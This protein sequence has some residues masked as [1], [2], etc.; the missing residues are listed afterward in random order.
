M[1]TKWIWVAL[2]CLL[3]SLAW[4]DIR[5][6]G[7]RGS[8]PFVGEASFWEDEHRSLTLAQLRAGADVH[9]QPLRDPSP[10]FSFS[11]SRYG[12]HFPLHNV[13]GE[14]QALVLDMAQ[15]LQDYLT[16]TLVDARGEVVAEWQTGDRLPA[17]SRALA[18]RGFAFPLPLAPNQRYDLYVQLD[19][20]DGLYDA[21]PLRLM[22]EEAFYNYRQR[23]NFGFGFYYGAIVILLLYNLVV[24]VSLKS[25]SFLL[26]SLYLTCF[27]VWNFIFRGYSVFTPL[28]QW[29]VIN[30]QLV[31]VASVALFASLVAFTSVFLE[32]KRRSPRYRQL[33]L[34]A[35]ALLLIPLLQSLL[36]FYAS[37]FAVLI[38]LA[39]IILVLVL[40][41]A[42][43][44]SLAGRRSARIFLLAW[45]L[46]IASALAYY[47]RVFG[48]LPSTWL[49]ENA[50]NIGSLIEVWVLALAL[51]D[52]IKRLERERRRNEQYM[53]VR[54]RELSDSLQAR[55]DEKTRE[56]RALNERL[57]EESI[58]DALTGLRNRRSFYET[59]TSE[60]KHSDRAGQLLAFLL[61]D[62]DYFKRYNDDY[63]HQAGDAVLKHFGEQLLCNWQRDT[64]SVFRL[65]GEEFGIVLSGVS[66]SD[67]RAKLDELRQRL[68]RLELDQGGP[69]TVS[70]GGVLVS[71]GVLPSPNTVYARADQALYSSKDQGRDRVNLVNLGAISQ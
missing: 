8:Y 9:W 28:G 63:G 11:S 37:T 26:Y 68:S 6:D 50:L 62:I 22:D 44:Q 55:V 17:D 58:T 15:P 5:I 69:L 2:G 4:G 30:N 57:A 10:N 49:T 19:S 71:P 1:G 53:L 38:P 46:L 7:E 25:R 14:P 70:V 65:G 54:E 52:R 3:A 51:A 60:L 18:Y 61:I 67:V 36:G 23:E 64:D 20:H 31:A 40:A 59:M 13:T 66:E 42:L 56:L 43:Q 21:I 45:S 16:V 48:W 12:L 32:L 35:C 41:V 24:G 29:S 47:A 33:L 27:L 34:V 39:V